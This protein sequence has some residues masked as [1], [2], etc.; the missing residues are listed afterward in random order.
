MYVSTKFQ[1]A[2]AG[3]LTSLGDRKSFRQTKEIP[4]I[5]VLRVTM[6]YLLVHS[7]HISAKISLISSHGVLL[8]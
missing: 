4:G 7:V 1:C 6:L 3:A 8:H 5:P 2:S